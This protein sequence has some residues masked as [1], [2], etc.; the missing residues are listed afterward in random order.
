MTAGVPG[1][2]IDL[3]NPAPDNLPSLVSPA[4][5]YLVGEDAPNGRII[6]AA[7]GRFASD[8]VFANSG[9][10]LGSDLDAEDFIEVAEQALD[11]TDAAPKNSFWR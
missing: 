3:D 10:N 6:Q 5:L 9:V 2:K 1:S 8:M 4:V 7:G 11:M